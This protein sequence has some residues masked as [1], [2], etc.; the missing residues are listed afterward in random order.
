MGNEM[1]R[2]L[3]IACLIFVLIAVN[4]FAGSKP[5]ITKCDIHYSNNAINANIHWQSEN[6]VTKVKIFTGP[7]LK[8]IAV[9]EYDNRRNPQGYSGEVSA[10]IPITNPGE[11][12]A[13]V[14][15]VEDD[16]HQKSEQTVGKVAA[17][18][19]TDPMAAQINVQQ[20]IQIGQQQQAT[21][22]MPVIGAPQVGTATI[23]TAP[24]G[25]TPVQDPAAA[26]TQMGV[27]QGLQ[28]GIQTG[29]QP[30]QT[31][32]GSPVADMV[33]QVVAAAAA[34]NLAPVIVE[35]VLNRPTANTINVKLKINDDKGLKEVKVKVIDANGG[36]VQEQTVTM[37]GK[38]W[39]GVSPDF[40]LSAGTFKVVAQATDEG[41][42]V[43]KDKSETFTIN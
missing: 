31:T 5:E 25:T 20:S 19:R 13:Y 14:V 43:S 17:I 26:G 1:K 18:T 16:L 21:Q 22:I 9:D 28:I 36:T 15:Q 38:T 40:A 8:E 27:Q 6:P 42:A 33:G 32:T 37:T 30:G 23:G 12:V 34:V 10:V 24:M 3:P 11:F 35:M 41:G 39:E 2:I 4:A 29:A 7:E